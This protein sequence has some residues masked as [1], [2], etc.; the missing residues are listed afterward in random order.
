M[1][2]FNGLIIVGL[3]ATIWADGVFAEPITAAD[4]VTVN[5]REWAQPDLFLWEPW[6]SINETCPNQICSGVLTMNSGKSFDMDG[7]IWASV[8]DVMDLFNTYGVSPALDGSDRRNEWGSSWAPAFFAD[9]W[10]RT[11]ASFSYDSIEGLVGGAQCEHPTVGIEFPCNPGVVDRY[12]PSSM[13][14]MGNGIWIAFDRSYYT[15]GAWMYR[16]PSMVPLPSTV[17]LFAIA[18]LA[19]FYPRR[20]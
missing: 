9:G 7:W 15:I 17:P 1:S 10:R 16:D 5:G 12:S 2:K 13:D 18:L 11:V 14:E 8:D 3:I 19:L 4:I 6:R 20:V